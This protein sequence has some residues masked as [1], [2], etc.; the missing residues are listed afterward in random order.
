MLFQVINSFYLYFWEN[1]GKTSGFSRVSCSGLILIHICCDWIFSTN[2]LSEMCGQLNWSWKVNINEWNIVYIK[3]SYALKTITI[4]NIH[5][6][7]C[8]MSG[9]DSTID[10]V[11]YRTRSTN[12]DFWEVVYIKRKTPL[13]KDSSNQDKQQF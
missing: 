9:C 4:G 7:L 1:T 6:S 2:R 3:G 10:L 5:N 13:Q 8:D 11:S 12:I